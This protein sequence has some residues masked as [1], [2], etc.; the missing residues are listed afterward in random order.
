MA[1]SSGNPRRRTFMAVFGVFSGLLLGLVAAL[2]LNVG[3][4]GAS[5]QGSEASHEPSDDYPTNAAGLSYG[6]N[7]DVL[8]KDEPDLIAVK[9]DSGALGYVMKSELDEKTNANPPDAKTALRRQEVLLAMARKGELKVAVF[10]LEGRQIDWLTLDPG[11]GSTD[12]RET[13]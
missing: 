9:G 7:R 11:D 4:S 6:S 2:A 1:T 10:D 3:T 12:S 5:A 13:Q 8:P